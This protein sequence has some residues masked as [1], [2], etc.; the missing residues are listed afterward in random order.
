MN[1]GGRQ[2]ATRSTSVVAILSHTGSVCPG[3]LATAH[4]PLARRPRG[5]RHCDQDCQLR[6]RRHARSRDA[7][8][9]R[10][11]DHHL[12]EPR[13]RP[14][15]FDPAAPLLERVPEHQLDVAEAAS[16]GRRQ[17]AWRR[18]RKR[19]RLHQRHRA[20][21]CSTPTAAKRTCRRFRHISPDD[22]NR[23]DRSLAAADLPVA[24]AARRDDAA[25]RDVDGTLSAQLRSHRR[26]R[27]LLLR[28]AMV[29]EAGRV[30]RR[31][32]DRAPVLRQL[33][34]LR[35]L[36]QLR[37]AHDGAVGLDRR[38]H[39]RRAVAHARRAIGS[40]IATCED[41]VHD[42]A[43]TTSPDF[44]ERTQR[45][46]HAGL[47]PVQHAAADAARTRRIS[48]IAISPP[49]RPRCA[50]TANGSARIRIHR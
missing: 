4:P 1:G 24:R 44:V 9:D 27:Q 38:R 40:R 12:A 30:R 5:T 3:T 45:F 21:A 22:Q 20:E 17:P 48:P 16:A 42:F 41:N 11:R 34:V 25:A 14:G 7:H 13:R 33:G 31:R 46:E 2:K 18:S 36:R 29:P 49:P 10:Q 8:A 43:W 26:D 39:R 6:H 50:I 32:L 23:D 35:R 15:L 28:L 47:P 19:L 37:R